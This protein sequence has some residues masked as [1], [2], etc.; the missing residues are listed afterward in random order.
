MALVP[1]PLPDVTV[2]RWPRGPCG[3]GN[4]TQGQQQAEW[5]LVGG[6]SATLSHRPW[7]VP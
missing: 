2:T 4:L 1:A 3:H 7:P 5:E 6:A